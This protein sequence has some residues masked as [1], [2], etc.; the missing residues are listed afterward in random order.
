MKSC[1]ISPREGNSSP[2]YVN[3]QLESI[4]SM[5]LPNLGFEF[6]LDYALKEH[7]YGKW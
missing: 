5:R 2:R 3:L 4:N 6:Y 1:T 7:K